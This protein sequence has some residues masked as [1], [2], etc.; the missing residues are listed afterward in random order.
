MD[1]YHAG[2]MARRFQ[3]IFAAPDDVLG[4]PTRTEASVLPQ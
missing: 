2:I 3:E 1:G 4:A